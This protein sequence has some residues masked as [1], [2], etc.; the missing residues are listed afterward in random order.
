MDTD[1]RE[2]DILDLPTV[3]V[4]GLSERLAPFQAWRPPRRKTN[5]IT[6]Q[7]Q[8]WHLHVGCQVCFGIG[9]GAWL[10]RDDA[11]NAFR[12]EGDGLKGVN[13]RLRV[14]HEHGAL[15]AN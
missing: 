7:H 12:V 3:L 5:V 14:A 4:D 6:P 9:T 2:L 15:Q 13:P 11:S 1:L 8:Y 10:Y